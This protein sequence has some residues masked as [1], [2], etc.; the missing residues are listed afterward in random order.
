[1]ERGM[2]GKE[3]SEKAG[4]R[5]KPHASEKHSQPLRSVIVV[6]TKCS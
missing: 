1:M 3:M 2:D 4:L 5:C 6:W